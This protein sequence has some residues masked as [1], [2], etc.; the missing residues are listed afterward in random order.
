[1]AD[2]RLPPV[3]S[4]KIGKHSKVH[5]SVLAGDPFGKKCAVDIIIPFHGQYAKVS[6]LVE[7]ILYYTQG[8]MLDVCLV[9]DASPNVDYGQ[10]LQK[11]KFHVVRREEQGG[12]GASLFTGFQ[13]TKSPWVCFMHSDCK[14]ADIHWLKSMGLLLQK[15]KDQGVKMIGARSNN[16]GSDADPRMLAEHHGAMEDFILDDDSYLPL[17]CALMSR[18]LFQ[19]IGGFVR[20]YPYVGYEDQ[21]LAHRMRKH[22][23]RQAVCGTSWVWHEGGGTI[24]ELV[25]TDSRIRKAVEQDN[26]EQCIKHIQALATMKTV[27]R[28]QPT[29]APQQPKQIMPMPHPMP[30]IDPTFDPATFDPSKVKSVAELIQRFGEG[31]L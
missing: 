13:E 27:R 5:N 6:R 1:M 7:S 23:F 25:R 20:P 4:R 9:D 22:G 26:R 19:H 31:D 2:R 14:I 12:F 30:R 24:D 15:L 28:R 10:S 21:E 8:N 16:P 17:Y 29:I 11:A 3:A 18:E